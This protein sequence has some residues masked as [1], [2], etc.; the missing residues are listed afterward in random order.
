MKYCLI[1]LVL[2]TELSAQ[3]WTPVK[4]LTFTGSVGAAT[5]FYAMSGIP[6]RRAPFVGRLTASAQASILGMA[7]GINLSYSTDDSKVRQSINK[8]SLNSTIRG[9]TFGVGGVNPRLSKYSLSGITVR[10][11]MIGIKPKNFEL[12]LTG[13][14]SRRATTPST[15]ETFRQPAADQ[16]LWG[17]Q[18][19]WKKQRNAFRLATLYGYDKS[20]ITLPGST[21]VLLPAQNYVFAPQ[22]EIQPFKGLNLKADLSASVYSRDR[23]TTFTPARES[24][25]GLIKLHPNSQV[26]YAGEGALQYALGIF[27]V[28]MGYERIEQGF[29]SMGLTQL[30]TD[31]S[32]FRLQP[33][34]KLLDSKM[35]VKLNY[36]DRTSNLAKTRLITPKRN[37]Y[38]ANITWNLSEQLTVNTAYDLLN[39]KNKLSNGTVDATLP[40]QDV[41]TFLFAPTYTLTKNELTHALSTNLSYQTMQD[42]RDAL[43]SKVNNFNIGSNYGLSFPNKHGANAGVNYLKSDAPGTI[44]KA[45]GVQLGYT[46]PAVGDKLNL[47]F[48]L[49]FSSN[50]TQTDAGSGINTSIKGSQSGLTVG[51][52]YK[53]PWGDV[54]QANL[55]GLRNKQ[56]GSGSFSEMQAVF[57]LNHVF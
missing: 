36:Q 56:D 22:F 14:K 8:L 41:H 47:N 40:R 2:F 15:E 13:G 23:E 53:L 4:G 7:T 29:E 54:L 28:M 46:M 25:L 5:E 17:M 9:V 32:V 44:T 10:G 18:V 3:G 50:E 30:R 45:A 6:D 51:A 37:Q 42:V 27:K 57:Q 38:G 48:G 26:A 20:E 52:G 12:M 1:L 49:N 19:G 31:Q 43:T 34:F 21:Q 55:R 33:Q 35:T 11:G 24:I 16:M 39:S